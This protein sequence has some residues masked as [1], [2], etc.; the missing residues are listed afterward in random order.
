MKHIYLVS[1]GPK[2]TV[3]VQYSVNR[4]KIYKDVVSSNPPS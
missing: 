2:Y 3:D 4:D 1:K